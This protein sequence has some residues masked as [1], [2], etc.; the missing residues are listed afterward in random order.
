[1][2]VFL[3]PRLFR[4]RPPAVLTCLQF[5]FLLRTMLRGEEPTEAGVPALAGILVKEPPK[6]G[7][8]AGHFKPLRSIAAFG[9]TAQAFAGRLVPGGL[10]NGRCGMEDGLLARWAGRCR[11]Q[12][13]ILVEVPYQGFAGRT[14]ARSGL[15]SA[16]TGAEQK[17]DP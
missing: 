3:T 5:R 13:A 2:Q 10:T 11:E 14:G 17:R 7:T 8:P 6:G 16:A 15:K 4:D 12:Q 9:P 1:M